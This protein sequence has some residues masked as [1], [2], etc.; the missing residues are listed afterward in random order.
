MSVAQSFKHPRPLVVPIDRTLTL[1]QL[2]SDDPG[3]LLSGS[4]AN[5]L[6]VTLAA[7]RRLFWDSIPPTDTLSIDLAYTITDTEGSV[8]GDYTWTRSPTGRTGEPNSRV[9][10]GLQ[11]LGYIGTDVS[12]SVYEASDS[13][14]S[15]FIPYRILASQNIEGAT[16]SIVNEA[17]A[18]EIEAQADIDERNHER[19]WSGV[20]SLYG[21]NLG[22]TVV[23]VFDD[24]VS[25][26]SGSL[27]FTKNGLETFYSYAP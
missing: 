23:V 7:A 16:W 12:K 18:L 21:L 6:S 25:S 1:A 26:V 19:V 5:M 15:F 22:C 13:S 3:V 24:A 2:T 20:V 10:S 17:G 9:V 11:N 27:S 8:S 14:G 4:P